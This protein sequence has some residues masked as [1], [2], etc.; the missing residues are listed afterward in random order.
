MTQAEI[1]VRYLKSRIGEWIMSHEIVKKETPWGYLGTQSDRRLFEI[2]Q[3]GY[4]DSPNYRYY[5][6]HQPPRSSDNPSKFARFRISKIEKLPAIVEGRVL[7][8]FT[9]ATA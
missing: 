1:V 2:A 3:D 4:Y 8:D 7:R 9:F 5:I 6:E